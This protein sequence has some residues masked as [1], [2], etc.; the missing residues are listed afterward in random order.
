MDNLEEFFV[1]CSSVTKI[2]SDSG[3]GKS[4]TDKMKIELAK[5]ITKQE[6]GESLTPTQQVR[7]GVLE[8]KKSY[9]PDFDISEGAKTYAKTFVEQL[10]YGYTPKEFNTLGMLKG[11]ICEDDSIEVY[12]ICN[13]RP[14]SDCRKNEVKMYGKYIQGTL[15]VYQKLRKTVTDIKTAETWATFPTLVEDAEK[16]AIEAGYIDQ[17]RAYM[18]L[19]DEMGGDVETGEVSFVMVDTPLSLLLDWRID[20]A[21]YPMHQVKEDTPMELQLTTVSFDRCLEWEKRTRYKL[22]E[23][24]RYADWYYQKIIEKSKG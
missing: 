5:L 16:K 2:L 3:R 18:M 14:E 11:T 4:L 12:R 21:N 23:T 24:A 10:V 9:K 22:E 7:L 13:L 1:R 6:Q 15:D 8:E 20:E 19:V 17:V